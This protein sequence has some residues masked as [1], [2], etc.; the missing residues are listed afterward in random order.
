MAKARLGPIVQSASGSIGSTTFLQVGSIAHIQQRAARV[1]RQT[2]AQLGRRQALAYYA[3]L[4]QTAPA[5]YRAAWN[6][7]AQQANA[8]TPTGGQR[9]RSGRAL[10]LAYA[11]AFPGPLNPSLP[12]VPTNTSRALPDA[13]SI[14][15]T[16]TGTDIW[17]GLPTGIANIIVAVWA[18]R[19]FSLSGFTRRNYTLIAIRGFSASTGWALDSYLWPVLGRPAEGEL[20]SYRIRSFNGGGLFSPVATFEGPNLAFY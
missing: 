16:D 3:A 14:S 11:A 18:A 9:F 19:S 4:W 12:T 6:T 1:D 8:T 7:L 13:L 20:V 17:T 2:T 15:F 10:L 5:E